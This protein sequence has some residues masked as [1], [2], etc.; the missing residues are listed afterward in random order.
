[1]AKVLLALMVV[2]LL[3]AIAPAILA[4]IRDPTVVIA[5]LVFLAVG[6]AVGHVLGGP[7]P[8]NSV[9]LALSTACRHPAIALSIAAANFPEE[10]FDAII[11][12]YLILGAIAAVPYLAWHRRR[13]WRPRIGGVKKKQLD[14]LA[15]W[16]DREAKRSI[17][18]FVE[19]VTDQK[20]PD[21]VPAADRIA[22]FDND[23]T[24]WCEQP[25]YIQLAFAL[26]RVRALVTEH[27]EWR[28]KQPFKAVLEGD[29]QA[30]GAAGAKGLL[31]DQWLHDD[32]ERGL[33]D[34]K[35]PSSTGR[36]GPACR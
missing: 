15:S 26:E 11:L 35:D 34:C 21:Y 2:V 19:A 28:A 31:R 12:L 3:V 20:G 6:L 13:R 8:N 22:V 14:L 17:I 36:T 30:L 10:R 18:E 23:G 4:V 9:V 5:I 29:M 1:M 16:N 25:L 27:P 7:N 33:D 24:L 32:D